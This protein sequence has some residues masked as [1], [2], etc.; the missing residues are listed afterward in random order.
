MPADM[1]ANPQRLHRPDG[2]RPQTGIVHLGLGAFYR[3]HGA[4]YIEQAMEKSG[5]DWGIVGVSLMRPD[6][7]DALAPRISPIPPLS[8]GRM[9]K[10][11]I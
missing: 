5:G 8:L 1:S 10:R 9:A 6:Q 7:R 3:A 11:R 2:T 4:I